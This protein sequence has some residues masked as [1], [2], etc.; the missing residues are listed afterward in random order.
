[1]ERVLCVLGMSE[2]VRPSTEQ[3]HAQ[4]ELGRRSQWYCISG[5]GPAVALV[6]R[7][8]KRPRVTVSVFL[9]CLTLTQQ[10]PAAAILR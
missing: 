3:K 5:V 4:I 6:D 10:L 9:W 1:M 2:P 8:R 7:S